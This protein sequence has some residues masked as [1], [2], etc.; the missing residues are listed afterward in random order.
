MSSSPRTRPP[1]RCEWNHHRRDC[2]FA[3]LDQGCQTFKSLKWSSVKHLTTLKSY[4]HAELGEGGF[5]WW[6]SSNRENLLRTTIAEGP[7]F[8]ALGTGKEERLDPGLQPPTP[9]GPSTWQR[10][11]ISYPQFLLWPNHFIDGE[12]ADSDETSWFGLCLLLNSFWIIE[13]SC[14]FHAREWS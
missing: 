6:R 4:T 9:H 7:F 5:W 2:F 14:Y 12:V 10:W 11:I 8:I 13:S 1:A 3:A